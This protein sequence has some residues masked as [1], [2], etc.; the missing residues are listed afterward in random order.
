MKKYIIL[1]AAASTLFTT[2]CMDNYLDEPSNSDTGALTPE[3]A[4][5]SYEGTEAV[6]AGLLR[7]QR[8]QWMDDTFARSTSF[9]GV[10]ALGFT[11]AVKGNDLIVN[12]NWYLNE[13]L[14]NDNVRIATSGRAEFSWR[15]PYAMIS[16]LNQM[17]D[18]VALSKKLSEDDKVDF[19]AQARALRG[20]Y[21]YQLALEFNHALKHDP[22]AAAAPI[23]LHVTTVGK[24]MSKLSDLYATIVEDLNFS[25]DN[26]TSNRYDNSWIN[27]QV[28][29]GMLANVYLSMEEW[30]KAEDMA[31]I[32]Y[33]NDVNGAMDNVDTYQAIGFDNPNS[34]EWLWSLTQ[35]TDQSN[36]YYL[37]PHAFM[38]RKDGYKNVYL[39]K[40]FAAL[41]TPDDVRTAALGNNEG[42]VP[43]TDP[44]YW[45][46]TK[47]T[48]AFNA[49]S[50]LMR[51]VEM[52]LVAAEAAYHQGNTAEANRIL[53]EFKANRYKGYTA[54]NLSG[55]ALLEDILVERRKELY[56]EQTG[57]EW[58]D[59]KRL[60]RGIKRTGN[61]GR[62]L[63]LAPNDKRF[64]LYIPQVEIDNN[65]QID[66]NVNAGR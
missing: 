4:Y 34:K 3:D 7:M 65:P 48:F 44:R 47:F 61:H 11:R 51:T 38:S 43:D 36:Y 5:N 21:Y 49:S 31:K 8:W 22:N 16:R 14:N 60:Q 39:N 28:A 35:R 37:A 9:G 53:N 40:D 63:E 45:Y 59:A 12:N 33:G 1:L 23:N 64:I 19:T 46:S 18:G 66:D 10:Y 15:F 57:V 6:M 41:F 30:K 20:Y 58:F 25:V 13:Y 55:D 32:A 52:I 42:G 27:K 2:S 17:I 26:L 50:P 56:G 54:Q 29:A 24:P 62:P